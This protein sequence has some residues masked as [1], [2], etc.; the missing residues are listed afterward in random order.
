MDCYLSGNVFDYQPAPC[1]SDSYGGDHVVTN[2]K[3][4]SK[5][6]SVNIVFANMHDVL[7]WLMDWQRSVIQ[8]VRIVQLCPR[9]GTCSVMRRV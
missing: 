5:W 9:E 7:F 6:W 1:A 2:R 4:T 3:D 8:T